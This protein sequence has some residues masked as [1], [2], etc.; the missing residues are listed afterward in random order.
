MPPTEP[1]NLAIL[2]K[3]GRYSE[4]GFPHTGWELVGE[5]DLGEPA[6]VCE[7]CCSALCRYTY[8]LIHP[9]FPGR[10]TVGC[11]CADKLTETS[12]ASERERTRINRAIRR[13]KWVT[14][15]GW[16]LSANGN[17]TLKVK[18]ARITLREE[19]PNGWIWLLQAPP[20]EFR[21]STSYFASAEIA[22]LEAFDT[23]Y[24]EPGLADKARRRL[25]AFK[26]TITK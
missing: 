21:V 18:G 4:L 19:K 9:A 3:H 24:P 10:I 7:A 12:T 26:G 6:H 15:K 2:Q 25:A 16:K 23:L 20:S 17:P 8:D 11:V 13:K 5:D 14:R 22:K 1:E